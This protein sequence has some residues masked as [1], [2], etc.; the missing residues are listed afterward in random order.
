M[1][2][3][4]KTESK[5]EDVEKRAKRE[6]PTACLLLRSYAKKCFMNVNINESRLESI[7]PRRFTWLFY[8][9]KSQPVFCC[10][11]CC[12]CCL[13][14]WHCL[15]WCKLLYHLYFPCY[16]RIKAMAFIQIIAK[17]ANTHMLQKMREK[18]IAKHNN[19]NAI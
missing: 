10:C 14:H 7:F 15:R 3:E 8:K 6:V 11:C 12:F 4:N 13:F 5:C 9:W 1:R 18:N 2:A 16:S 19:S 17:I